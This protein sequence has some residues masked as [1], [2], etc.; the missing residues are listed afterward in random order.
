MRG[1]LRVGTVAIVGVTGLWGRLRQMPPWRLD[2]VLATL[3]VVTALVTTS[4]TDPAYEARDGVAVALVLTATVPYYFRRVAPL[5]VL[6]VSLSATGAL[7]LGGYDAGALP[8]LVAVGIYT[9][10]AYRPA[11][12]V[13][14]AG[15]F[16]NGVLVAMLVG[17]SP[18]FDV[19]E[20]A[21]TVPVYLAT[22]LVGWT[23]QSRRLREDALEREQGEAALRA[24]A[25]ERLRIAQ[26]LHDVI[27]HSLGVIA[28]QAGVGMH[29]I[30]TDPDE[31]KR[32]LEHISRTSRTSLAEIRRLLGLVRS[33][34]ATTTYAPTPTLDDLG[35]LADEVSDAGLHVDLDVAPDAHDLPP[36]VELAA[37]RIVQ[38]ALTNARKHSRGAR[39]ATVRLDVARGAL[40]VVVTDDGVASNGASRGT[41][42][43]ARASGHGLIGMRERVAVYG[44]SLDAGPIEGGGYRVTATLPYDEE[45]A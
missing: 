37:Y 1:R 14:A 29:L 8:F 44:G 10:G 28:V 36:G 12:E 4:R 27:G 38:E 26:E 42:T 2:A 32:A 11:R 31:A 5:A 19:P 33:G 39:R 18:R 41:G 40:E 9:V 25:D 20:F 3:F 34:D 23:M 30:E 35:R 45:G 24:A 6:V 43:G 13:V 22:L 16:Q 21:A 17:D 7:F 15:V